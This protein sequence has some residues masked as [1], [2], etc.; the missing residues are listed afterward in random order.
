MV[1]AARVASM[2]TSGLAVLAIASVALAQMVEPPKS[3]PT[4]TEPTT[5]GI[6]VPPAA[7]TVVPTG[8][9]PVQGETKV[10]PV[11]RVAP[12][13]PPMPT[14]VAKAIAQSKTKKPAKAKTAAATAKCGPGETL[15]RKTGTCQKK[16][17]TPVKT[18]ALTTNAA[19]AKLKKKP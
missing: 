10:A 17:P 1:A 5:T 3:S 8:A 12:K 15:V 11:K 18:A 14:V 19:K 6:A 16:A 13:T 9:A 7:T 2:L 4:G